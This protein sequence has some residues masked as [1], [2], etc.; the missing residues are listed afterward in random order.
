MTQM[1]IGFHTAVGGINQGITRDYFIPLDNAGIPIVLKSVSDFG[2]CEEVLRFKQLSGVDHVVMFRMSD[3]DH[4]EWDLPNYDL[5]P[6]EAFHDHWN[7]LSNVLPPEYLASNYY[8]ENVI[9]QIINEPDKNRAD[10][11]GWF[12]YEAGQFAVAN[13]LIFAMPSFSTGEPEK[14]HWETPGMLAFL[15]Y[16]GNH[17]DHVMIDLHE[18]SLSNDDIWAPRVPDTHPGFWR[19]GRFQF[20]L[21]VCSAHAIPFPKITI[22][23]FGWNEETAPDAELAMEHIIEANSL[24]DSFGDL[25]VGAGIWCLGPWHGNIA[26]QVHDLIVPVA[27]YAL[28]LGGP[29]PQPDEPNRIKHTIHLLPQDTTKEETQAVSSHLLPTRTGFTHSHDM[30]E[31][32]MFHSTPDG[33]IHAWDEWRWPMNLEEQFAWLHVN[34]VPREFEE[35]MGNPAEFRFDHWPTEHRVIT[36]TFGANT[37]YYAQFGLPGH[38]GVDIKAP[39]GSRLFAVAPGR[40]FDV[41]AY[42]D[43]H[44]YGIRVRV[45]HV[46]GYTL[47][48]AHLQSVNVSVG[49]EVVAGQVI[50]RADNTGNIISG[51]SHS[52]ITL[53]ND[54]AYEGG[55]MYIGYPY[56]IVDPTPFLL[57]FNPTFPNEPA[58][59]SGEQYDLVPYLV[60]LAE[61]GPLYE[62]QTQY[63]NAPLDAWEPGPQQRHQTQREPLTATTFYHTKNNEWEQLAFDSQYILRSIDTS[64][65][66][67]GGVPRYYELE[68]N[69]GDKW[70]QW[71]LRYM[72]IGATYYREPYVSFY[73]KDNCVLLSQDVAPSLIKLINVHD[74]YEFYTGIVLAD[75]AELQWQ[76]MN[77]IPLESYYYAQEFGLVGWKNH[78]GLPIRRAAISEIHAPGTRPDNVREVINCI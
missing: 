11:L 62:V 63:Y 25:I 61:M 28:M 27:N 38:E 1:R 26:T 6:Q 68:D 7:T 75:V 41:V 29:M 18:Y 52:H 47:T 78:S 57:P 16:A 31:A 32:V 15:D 65:G 8:C 36:Q 34:Y 64:P 20:M 22:G 43:G 55:P 67:V 73:N 19:V 40:V 33:E 77:G 17:K 58:P 10:W 72:L 53:K 42:D 49:D 56:N 48:Y 4:P 51:Q 54:E 9:L 30:V 13:N 35:I 23:E 66:E 71:C 70:S 76:D 37:S 69:L 21:D 44:N 50:G 39:L 74:V 2:I 5:P 3:E 46:E 14:D 12:C 45:E 24:Y 60:P 59:P